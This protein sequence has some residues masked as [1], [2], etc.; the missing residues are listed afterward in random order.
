MVWKST[1]KN[2]W[3]AI[4]EFSD[5]R[6]DMSICRRSVTAHTGDA[7]RRF[8]IA[9]SAGIGW[10]AGNVTSLEARFVRVSLNAS[11][12]GTDSLSIYTRRKAM[13]RGDYSP[14]SA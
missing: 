8:V 4:C 6:R 11:K 12:I 13:G 3:K 10:P 1:W 9:A 14:R 7:S 2:T 5:K